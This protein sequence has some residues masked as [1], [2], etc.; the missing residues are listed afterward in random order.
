MREQST[1][2]R[3]FSALALALLA[4]FLVYIANPVKLLKA[5]LRT[6]AKRFVLSIRYGSHLIDQV[7]HR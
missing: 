2:K 4:G 1:G 3:L 5:D 7:G 6:D